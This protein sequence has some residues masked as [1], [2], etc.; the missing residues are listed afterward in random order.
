[1]NEHETTDWLSGEF[2]Q[3]GID[4]EQSIPLPTPD[5]ELEM[6]ETE[7]PDELAV[8]AL[9]NTVLFPG[10]VLP[11]TVGRDTSLQLIKEAFDADRHVGVIA[12][13]DASVES[14]EPEDL[15]DVGTVAE[16]LRLIKMP[17]G[18]K[19]IVIQGKR[20]F[21]TVQYTE[22]EPYFVAQVEAFDE[23]AMTEGTDAQAMACARV[24]VGACMTE[25]SVTSTSR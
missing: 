9:R 1:M 21:H 25:C 4:P 7:V 8:L 14:P 18:S 11:I 20:R 2:D 24:R 12:Q 6:G 10:V 15:Y 22:T 17:D 13:R 16:I 23:H 3:L 19:H 5:E